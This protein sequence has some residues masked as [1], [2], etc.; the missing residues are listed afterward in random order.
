MN[1]LLFL[2]NFVLVALLIS[3]VWILMMVLILRKAMANE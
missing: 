2:I 3:L 1:R